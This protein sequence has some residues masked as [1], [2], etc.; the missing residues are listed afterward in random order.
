[1]PC[2]SYDTHGSPA[3]GMGYTALGGSLDPTN[4]RKV[5]DANRWCFALAQCSDGTFTISLIA[6]VPS[7]SEGGAFVIGQAL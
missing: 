3:M 5:M 7:T 4:F 1:M 2:D 6:T